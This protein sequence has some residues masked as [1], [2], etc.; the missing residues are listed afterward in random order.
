M[1]SE[2][3]RD[4]RPTPDPRDDIIREL[5]EALEVARE[6]AVTERD[7][8]MFGNLKADK[9]P[10]VIES[11]ETIEKIISALRRARGQR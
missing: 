1:T 9:D 8:R 3:Q 7:R 6:F 4:D 5:C 10:Y 2:N 11:N